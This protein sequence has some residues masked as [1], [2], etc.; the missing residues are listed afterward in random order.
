MGNKCKWRAMRRMSAAD[1]PS[2]EYGKQHQRTSPR[3]LGNGGQSLLTF[4]R[5]KNYLII[6]K[7]SL[8]LHNHPAAPGVQSILFWKVPNCVK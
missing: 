4:H 2:A 1:L 3:V 8:C 6:R 5:I 7:L